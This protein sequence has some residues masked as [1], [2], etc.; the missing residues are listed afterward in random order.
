[1]AT[2]KIVVVEA[3]K[4]SLPLACMFAHRGASVTVCDLNRKIVD[5]INR[6]IDPHGEPEQDRYVRDGV[7]A[8]GLRAS[9][10]TTREGADADAVVVLVSALLSAGR[11][12]ASGH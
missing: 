8:G 6:G 1:M 3:G 10:H 9:T 11:G 12:S 2:D 5:S 7:A 4:M